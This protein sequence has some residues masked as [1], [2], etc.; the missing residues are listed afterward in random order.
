MKTKMTN[1]INHFNTLL[2]N[3][4][5][6]VKEYRRFISHFSGDKPCRSH[7]SCSVMLLHTVTKVAVNSVSLQKPNQK[8]AFFSPD[9]TM[10]RTD[11]KSATPAT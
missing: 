5:L 3:I 11:T 6:D 4:N 10:A 9:T 8:V 1:I 7:D 2:I